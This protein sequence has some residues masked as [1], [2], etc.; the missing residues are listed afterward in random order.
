MKIRKL[1]NS[2]FLMKMI[3]NDFC[4]LPINLIIILFI[5]RNGIK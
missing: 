2:S 4:F 1:K 5:K 3:N